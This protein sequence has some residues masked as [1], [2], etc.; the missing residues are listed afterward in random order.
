MLNNKKVTESETFHAPAEAVWRA[1]TD[2]KLIKQ[3]FF[4]TDAESEWKKGSSITFTGEWEG[5]EYVDK[6]TILDIEE[7]KLLSFDYWSSVSGLDDKPENYATVTYKMESGNGQTELT[8]TQEGFKDEEA[9]EHSVS[10]WQEILKNLKALV[11]N[12]SF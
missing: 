12:K 2:K 7:E 9:Y 1:L 8:V 3:Y 11:E 4:G 6:G 5:Q 10:G